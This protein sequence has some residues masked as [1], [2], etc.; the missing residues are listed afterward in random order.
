MYP[1][2]RELLPA[3]PP[4]APR[5]SSR[6]NAMTGPIPTEVGLLSK[7]RVLYVA[8]NLHTGT[9]PTN[10]LHTSLVYLYVR[11]EALSAWYLCTARAMDM[12]DHARVRSAL[13]LR[14]R[15]VLCGSPLI[16]M[17]EG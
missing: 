17:Q 16:D 10:L 13:R 3:L 2:D 8:D 1:L 7:L 4:R 14:A 9:L 11:R 12:G 15:C 5:R 6:S